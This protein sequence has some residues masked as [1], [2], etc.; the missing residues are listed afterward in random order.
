M[1]DGRAVPNHCYHICCVK[2]SLKAVSKKTHLDIV[3]YAML[4]K[5]KMVEK[6]VDG[7]H[8]AGAGVCVCPPLFL[9][10]ATEKW[11][12]ESRELQKLT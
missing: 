7:L 1:L 6:A 4:M 5:P 10:K 3:G 12:I 9:K 8:I 11:H 2:L